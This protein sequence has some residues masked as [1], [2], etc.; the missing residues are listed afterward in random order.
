MPLSSIRALKLAVVA[1]VA[2]AAADTL[3]VQWTGYAVRPTLLAF[4]FAVTLLV[5]LAPGA[6]VALGSIVVA[7]PASTESPHVAYRIAIAAAVITFAAYHLARSASSARSVADA[8]VIVSSLVFLGVAVWVLRRSAVMTAGERIAWDRVCTRAFGLASVLALSWSFY[9]R[10]GLP[11][12]PR[13]RA[14]ALQT[15]SA[16]NLGRTLWLFLFLNLA[17]FVVFRILRRVA[18]NDI[19]GFAPT[20]GAFFATFFVFSAV[21]YPL[22]PGSWWQFVELTAAEDGGETATVADSSPNVIII[23]LDTV[24]AASLSVYGYERPTSP[25]LE[26]FAE[27]AHVF[28]QGYSVG[29]WSLPGHAS[30]LT[31]MLTHEHGAH[32][33]AIPVDV[34]EGSDS[35][36]VKIEAVPLSPDIDTLG[37]KFARRGYDTAAVV[38]NGFFSPY[39]GLLQ[40]FAYA[41]TRPQNQT[42][43]EPL[44]GPFARKIG[45]FVASRYRVLSDP[46]RPAGTIVDHTLEWVDSRRRKPFFVLMNFMDGH[47][48]YPSADIWAP[49]DFTTREGAAPAGVT[50]AMDRYDRAIRYL[51]YER[52]RF[53]EELRRR[54]L[55]DNSLIVVTADHGETFIQDGERGVHGEGLAGTDIRVPLLIKQP[56]QSQGQR[57]QRAVSLASI[58]GL[59]LATVD[60]A[61]TGA[62]R[63]DEVLA[64]QLM[65]PEAPVIA[66]L[67][68]LGG[69]ADEP[70][71]F[72]SLE[73]MAQRYPTLVTIVEYPWKF[74]RWS[75]GRRELFNLGDDPA[76]NQNRVAEH[77]DVANRL[78]AL[79]LSRVPLS[80]IVPQVANA[81]WTAPDEEVLSRL[82]A[83][84][85]VR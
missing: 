16:T 5:F 62:A 21:T 30:L 56:G 33:F 84:G 55:F 71:T 41:D 7:R 72:A 68:M 77:P 9:W 23:V 78:D 28:E 73:D 27:T 80:A 76:E 11:G 67:H 22:A 3:L 35:L 1:A 64:E 60:A 31:G 4:V 66:E 15:G 51:D 50:R 85:Y 24:R 6:L 29:S 36:K 52:G 74:I 44:A 57:W 53:F 17:L 39:Y 82:R 25:S 59:S 46:V 18:K 42:L 48:P 20:A 19:P 37:E 32:L 12:A 54:D 83:L 2:V 63:A 43:I 58:A 75:D 45:G 69:R 81:P 26:Q 13:M 49:S 40:G 38:A 10:V 65:N 8:P 79:L 14:I 34:A 47:A 70:V 61:S